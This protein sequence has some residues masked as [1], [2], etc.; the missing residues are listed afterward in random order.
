MVKDPICECISRIK[1][2]LSPNV[3]KGRSTIFAACGVR[4]GLYWMR[5]GPLTISENSL[6]D[7][8]HIRVATRCFWSA[9]INVTRKF[10]LR[11]KEG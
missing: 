1:K 10:E 4:N 7:M 11:E 9:F 6:P 5:S 8:R 3:D 2:W